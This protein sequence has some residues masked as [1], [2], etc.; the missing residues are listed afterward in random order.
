MKPSLF[1]VVRSGIVRALKEKKS[2]LPVAII[3][4]RDVKV[5]V[6]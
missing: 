4:M 1:P 3:A 6:A 2:Q 5:L